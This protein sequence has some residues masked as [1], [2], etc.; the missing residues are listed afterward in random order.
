MTADLRVALTTTLNDRLAGPLRRMLGDVERGFQ[1]FKGPDKVRA[2]IV[3]LSRETELAS[4]NAAR[5]GDALGKIPR[6]AQAA[7][8]VM[9]GFSA[10]KMV[11]VNPLQ[12]QRTYGRQLADL[13]N[14]AYSDRDVQG[15]IA[16]MRSLDEMVVGSLRAGGGKRED[17]LGALNKL[18][19]MGGFTEKQLSTVMPEIMRVSTASGG[20]AVEIAELVGKALKNG[21]E[22]ADVPSM[23]GKAI[24]SGQ[25]GGFEMKDMSKWLPKLLAAGSTIGM[26]GMRDYEEILALAQTSATTSGGSDE[27]GNNLLNFLL[28]VN[29]PDTQNDARKQGI[30]LSGTLLKNRGE[31][32]SAAMAFLGLLRNSA[33]HD[34]RMIKLRQQFAGAGTDGERAATLQAQQ[35]ILSGTALGKFLQDRQALMPA[36]AA[37]N[38]PA[39]LQ[40]QLAAVRAGGAQ[41][42]AAN[43]ET[44]A[45]TPDFRMQQ[46]EN[47]QLFAQTRALGAVNGPLAGLAD[48]TVALYREFPHL[49]EAMESAK[50]AASALAVAAAGAAGALA[51]FGLAGRGGAG[52][53]AVGGAAAAARGVGYST[54]WNGASGGTAVAGVGG[55]AAAGT[56]A[57]PAAVL[58]AGM[59][60][61][62]H[63]NSAKGLT[64][65]IDTR[66]ERIREL[67][68]LASLDGNPARY[69]GE[70]AALE[71][72][73]DRLREQYGQAVGGGRGLVNPPMASESGS[74]D[75]IVRAIEDL[76]KRP[77]KVTLDGRDIS[78]A[79]EAEQTYQAGRR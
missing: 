63:L 49:A 33:D 42:T 45:A 79:V 17:A 64:A 12:Q 24:A 37:L 67:T 3:A 75:R 58:G 59:L 43:F 71:G 53:V 68:E 66:N 22:A 19:A 4:R 26:R 40:R 21:F 72:D 8:A 35:A 20:S 73:R 52:A 16:G 41:T 28:K 39:E 60:M 56:I 48:R 14:T 2:D 61:S 74:A 27:A 62:D 69:Q 38:N 70:I 47:E 32:M 29:S 15:R 78:S 77:I 30:D 1:S 65:R 76:G 51:L 10:A 54:L 7:G 36:I 31:G 23:L 6:L 13:A 55:L 50:L 46:S 44:I 25:A 9:A 5:L 11:L 57:L 18:M 34:P